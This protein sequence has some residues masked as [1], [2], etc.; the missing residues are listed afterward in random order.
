M[1]N[2][3]IWKMCPPSNNQSIILSNDETNIQNN[4]P[5]A[6]QIE[7][8]IEFISD[9]VVLCKLYRS[10]GYSD[11]GIDNIIMRSVQLFCEIVDFEVDIDTQTIHDMV[12]S[13]DD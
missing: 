10:Y 4:V 1:T 9:V 11:E 8:I 5:D 2:K 7:T 3:Q 12:F 13:D 6:I